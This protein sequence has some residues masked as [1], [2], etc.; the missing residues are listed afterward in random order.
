MTEAEFLALFTSARGKPAPTN[1]TSASCRR[2]LYVALFDL[3]TNV[4][5]VILTKV[6]IHKLKIV[7]EINSGRRVT[8]TEF[9]ALFIS[10]RGKPAPTSQ[11][12]APCRRRLYVALFESYTNAKPVTLTKVRIHK[13]KIVPEI[14]SG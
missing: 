14:N 8:E 12:S 10:A 13:F 7:P 6:R 1:Q 4:K 9:L 11:T 3:Y 2:R 5:P